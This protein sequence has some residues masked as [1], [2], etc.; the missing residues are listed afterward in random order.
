M[1][2]KS[3]KGYHKLIVWQRARELITL[4]YFSTENFPKS[5]EYSLKSQLRRA[6][7]SI[8]LNIVEGYRRYSSK[9]YLHFLNIA[10]GSLSEL[11]AAL[12]IAYDL[13]YFTDKE[14]S[15]IEA[16]RSQVGFLLHKLIKSINK[17]L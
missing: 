17:K 2:E 10:N 12:E 6:A 8:V 13:Q 7:V 9:D 1:T 4:L 3:N 15:V 14:Y 16:K 5:E 11:E